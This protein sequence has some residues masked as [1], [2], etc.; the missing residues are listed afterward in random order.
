MPLFDGLGCEDRFL[1]QHAVRDDGQRLTCARDPSP[2]ERHHV[3]RTWMRRPVVRLAIK[4]FVFQEEHRIVAADRCSQQSACVQSI[5]RKYHT[6][7]RDMRESHFAA[8]TVVH[9]TAVQIPANRYANHNRA[10]KPVIRSPA[11]IRQ[12]VS[13]LHHGRP[14]VIEELDF[15]YGLQASRCHTRSAPDNGS[16]SDGS[17]EAALCPELD[18]DSGSCFEYSALAL[19]LP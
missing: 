1:H 6:E 3:V 16:F 11:D 19:Y 18:L 8:L 10:G 17:V 14:D 7:P 4:A 9:R 13:N 15:R 2:S 12:F 5:R